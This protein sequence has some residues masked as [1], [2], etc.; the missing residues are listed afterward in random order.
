[1]PIKMYK[2]NAK[3]HNRQKKFFCGSLDIQYN[4]IF[5]A[6][7]ETVLIAASIGVGLN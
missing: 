7:S 4:L 2:C 5:R 3:K 1:M 6:D